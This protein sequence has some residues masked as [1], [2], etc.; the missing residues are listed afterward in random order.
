MENPFDPLPREEKNTI[1]ERTVAWR[2]KSFA[3]LQELSTD[4]FFVGEIAVVPA[5]VVWVLMF[6]GRMAALKS[7]G[8]A[9]VEREL[10][11]MATAPA[12]FLAMWWG[13]YWGIAAIC[14]KR[15]AMLSGQLV[16]YV[17]EYVARVVVLL[18]AHLIVVA[19]SV[20]SVYQIWSWFH[21][22]L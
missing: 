6:A 16:L 4:R 12:M 21:E 2:K 3:K 22:S 5:F 19:V 1:L 13:F 15:D 10:Y 14:G 18:A 9:T 8:T 20:F 7:S 11:A 17:L